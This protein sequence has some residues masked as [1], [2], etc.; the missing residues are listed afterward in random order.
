MRNATTHYTADDVVARTGFTLSAVL[1]LE[2]LGVFP[3]SACHHSHGRIWIAAEVDE[4]TRFIDEPG[5]REWVESLLPG[6]DSDEPTI[7]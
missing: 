2:H 3:S 7:R 5:V 1:W 6:S 4:W